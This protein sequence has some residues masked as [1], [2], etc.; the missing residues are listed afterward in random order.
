M[1]NSAR[2]ILITDFDGTLTRTDFYEVFMEAVFPPGAPDFWGELRGGQRTLFDTLR[3]VFAYVPVGEQMLMTLARR[4]GLEE[5]LAVSVGRL[6][7]AGWEVEVVSAG[8]RWYIDRLFAEAGVSMPV[9]ANPGH[10]DAAGRLRMTPPVDSPHFVPELG[11]SKASVVRKLVEAGRRVAYAGDGPPDV[12]AAR[13][14]PP[15]LRF[16]KRDLAA[17]LALEGESYRPFDRWSEVV[18]GLI[19]GTERLTGRGAD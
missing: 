17:R 19:A 14:V 16:A 3:D 6:R 11:V 4:V 12:P 1:N 18:D 8:C 7:E 15:E 10:V 13:L 9:Q 5:D 2:P